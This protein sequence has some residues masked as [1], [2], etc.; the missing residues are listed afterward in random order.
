MMPSQ[1]RDDGATLVPNGNV[2]TTTDIF[3]D[4]SVIGSLRF[5]A[6]DSWRRGNVWNDGREMLPCVGQLYHG[7]GATYN[8]S[9]EPV[10]KSNVGPRGRK[11]LAVAREAGLR[12]DSVWTVHGPAPVNSVV[13]PLREHGTA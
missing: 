2:F 3:S 4:D 6:R 1:A 7:I 8:G 10:A 5:H 11:E 13:M 12:A 9:C